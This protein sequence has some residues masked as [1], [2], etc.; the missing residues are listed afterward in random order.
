MTVPAIVLMFVLSLLL[1]WAVGARKRL[2]GLRSMLR[3][4]FAQLDGQLKRRYDL[5]PHLVETVKTDLKQSRMLLEVVIAGCNHAVV[6]NARAA[7]NPGDAAAVQA[8]VQSDGVLEVALGQMLTL[9][10]ACPALQARESIQQQCQ[11]LTDNAIRIAFARQAYNDD[12]A[13][14][15]ASL[16]QFPGSIVAALFGFRRA[17]L[18][19]SDTGT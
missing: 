11:A 9:V 12:A 10:Q 4:A 1:F 2:V 6:A 5:I 16:V 14:Y 3:T 18:L 7:A 8:M 15:N 19:Q 17:A 13:Q